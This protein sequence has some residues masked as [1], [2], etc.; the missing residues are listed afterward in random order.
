VNFALNDWGNYPKGGV[1]PGGAATPATSPKQLTDV[2]YGVIPWYSGAGGAAGA[3]G[4]AGSGGAGSDGQGFGAGGGGGGAA[5]TFS[6]ALATGGIGGR[7]APGLAIITT[8]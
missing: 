4:A 1:F 7:G 2:S 5:T 3:T 8:Y 6:A